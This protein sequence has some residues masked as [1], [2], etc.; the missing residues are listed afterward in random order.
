MFTT[1]LNRSSNNKTAWL[2]LA[3]KS[4]CDRTFLI[5]SFNFRILPSQKKDQLPIASPVNLY[6]VVGY[7]IEEYQNCAFPSLQRAKAFP[8]N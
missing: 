8:P 1:Y 7:D 5:V 3:P 2:S 4:R 6:Y